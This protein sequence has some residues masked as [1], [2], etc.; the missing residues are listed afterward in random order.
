VLNLTCEGRPVTLDPATHRRNLILLHQSLTQ[1]AARHYQQAG[2]TFVDVAHIVGITGACENVDTLFQIHSHTGQRRFFTQTGQ[3]ALESALVHFPAVWT[4]I[5]SGRAERVNDARH[6]HEFPLTEEE[7]DATTVGM[8][9]ED[10]DPEAMFVHLIFAISTAVRRMIG[11]VYDDH[12]DMLREQ[13]GRH[14]QQLREAALNTFPVITYSDAVQL[15]ANDKY[16][17][18]TFGDDLTAE[19][20]ARLLELVNDG[21]PMPVFVT[22]YPKDIKFFNMA[23]SRTDDR[24]CLS[25]DLILP[26]AGEAV[27]SAVREHDPQRLAIRLVDSRMYQAHRER[28]GSL[29]DFRWYLDLI[30][31][32]ITNP[33]AGYGLGNDRLIQYILGESDIRN[34]SVLHQLG[35]E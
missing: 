19:H 30:D 18:L 1:A 21:T 3:L 33:H 29:D 17:D 11:G 16:P 13:Y 9:R 7:L 32:Q 26:Y 23:V 22:H 8:S 10:Y 31:S 14:V 12:R 20:E 34:A 28:G 27:G 25:A 15:L 5:H 35:T 24:V 6:L 4:Q 2:R